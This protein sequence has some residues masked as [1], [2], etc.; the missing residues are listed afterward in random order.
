VSA[1]KLAP[2][3]QR[4][5]GLIREPFVIYLAV[6]NPQ[7]SLGRKVE[8]A[9]SVVLVILYIVNPLDLLPDFVPFGFIDD[10]IVISLATYFIE[11]LLPKEVIKESRAKANA[12]LR[13]FTLALDIIAAILLFLSLSSSPQ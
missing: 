9:L 10:L 3:F 2:R 4:W 12:R 6:R 1:T 8:A 11:R 13:P 5:V 7:T